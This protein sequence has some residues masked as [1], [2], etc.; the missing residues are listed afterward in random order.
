MKIL[1]A[2]KSFFGKI[3]PAEN[4]R[5]F[6]GRVLQDYLKIKTELRASD[7]NVNSNG[8]NFK[9]NYHGSVVPFWLAC[10]DGVSAEKSDL[11]VQDALAD[12]AVGLVSNLNL[13]E[14]SQILKDTGI[15]RR[16]KS[17]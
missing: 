6:S 14:I 4:R 7:I 9:V 8:I 5:E 17:V 12:I 3:N 1:A 15:D 16:N 13:V 11:K 10:D 2:I